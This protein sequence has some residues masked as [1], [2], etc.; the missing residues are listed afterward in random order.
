MS[1][2]LWNNAANNIISAGQFPLPV[3]DT[4]LDLL[5]T[6]INEEQ[7]SF[8]QIF[9]KPLNMNEIKEKSG[10][11]EKS[12]DKMLNELMDKG[13]VTGIPSKSSG[14]IVYR[15]MPPIPGLFEFTMMRGQTGEKE[16]K[17]ARLF[18]RIFGELSDMVQGNYDI[19]VQVLKTLP[20][21]TRVV[22]VESQ[23]DQ[24]FDTVMPYEDVKKI[25]DR[26]DTFAVS[27]C[28]CRHKRFL[29]GEACKATKQKENCLFF[30]LNARF[31]LDHNFGKP[32]SREDVKRILDESEEAGLVHKT[33]HVK[34]DPDKEE[35]AICN[36]CKCCCATFQLY[37]Q[38]ALAMHTHTSY[39][40]KIDKEKCS[41]CEVCVDMCPME[42]IELKENTAD[43]DVN[44]CIGC[45]VCAYHC[46][47]EALKLERTGMREVF[48]PPLRKM[49]EKPLTAKV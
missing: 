21:F 1:E 45:G 8:I 11:D 42:A 13:V 43:L 30:G 46:S 37:Y 15:L 40:A 38:G 4:L 47:T 12:L 48:V 17:L 20:P 26:F 3:N 9:K 35:F 16:K 19:S 28:Y 49:Q 33:F 23:V 39:V 34:A 18:S 36:C 22:P 31:V 14:I 2:E 32:V 7:A 44:K 6:I 5:Q 10:L 27:H 24:K 29:L 25:I 41:G